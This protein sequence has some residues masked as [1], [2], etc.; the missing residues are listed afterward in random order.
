MPG[1]DEQWFEMKFEDL[2]PVCALVPFDAVAHN[3]GQLFCAD[4]WLAW[5]AEGKGCANCRQQGDA[6]PSFRD[7]HN[8]LNFRMKCCNGCGEVIRLGSKDQHLQNECV[9][10]V[11]LCALCKMQI[12]PAT[13]ETHN[14]NTCLYRITKCVECDEETTVIKLPTHRQEECKMR[15]V[16]C[17]LCPCKVVWHEMD[18]HLRSDGSHIRSM[19]EQI[20]QLRGI[21]DVLSAKLTELASVK[22]PSQV[23]V[24]SLEVKEEKNELLGVWEP[25]LSE[26]NNW[27]NWKSR[28]AKKVK[29]PAGADCKHL[30]QLTDL[31]NLYASSGFADEDLVHLMLYKA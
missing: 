17:E 25:S 24:T 23:P 20:K 11:I 6:A 26:W 22:S 5:R 21:V 4:C 2:C 15:T 8:V 9:N 30:E 27:T 1:Y 16:S 3:C 29:L 31:Q 28:R 12:T 7:R 14:A 13:M 10:R 19:M 18:E